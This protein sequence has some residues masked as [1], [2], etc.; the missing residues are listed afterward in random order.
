MERNEEEARIATVAGYECLSLL[1]HVLF[2][3]YFH[4]IICILAQR[5]MGLW[6]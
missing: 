1:V 3:G 4:S 5:R 2:A 6:W